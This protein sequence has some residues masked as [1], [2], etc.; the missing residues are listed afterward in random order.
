MS[1][2]LKNNSLLLA[3]LLQ[4]LPLVKTV[5]T[6]PAVASTWAIVFRWAVGSTAA[7]GAFDS[8][9][10]ATSVFTTPS[11]FNGAVGT[12]FSAN[13]TVSIGGGNN[14]ASNDYL[15]VSSGGVNSPL[16]LNNQ[17]TT[18]TMPPGLT[19]TATWVNGATTI[20]GKITGTPTTAG[21]YTT[22][23]TVVSPGNASLSQNITLYIT[24]SSAPTAP[25]FTKQPA[26]TNVIAGRNAVFGVTCSGTT[27]MTYAW[28]KN[29]SPL[30]DGG[31]IS[32]SS[33]TT[34]TV[35]GVS[36]NDAGS[37]TMTASNSVGIATS[38][39]AV[40]TVIEA[41][42]ITAQPQPQNTANGGN[43]TF[44]VTA[45]GTA[46]LAYSWQK[47]GGALANGG[48][49]SGATS[50]AL[51][52]AGIATTDAGNYSVVISNPA[53]SVTSSPAALA[54]VSS[55]TIS[56]PLA[57]K[58]VAV[59]T[60]VAFTITAAG[61]APL[62]YFWQRNGSA[63]ADGGN[64]VGSSTA[65]LNLSSLTTND[66]GN[67]SVI[68]SNALGT[69]TNSATLTVLAPATIVT[70]PVGSTVVAGGSQ[71]FTVIAS[72]SAPLAYQWRKNGTNL[73]GANTATL[74]LVNISANA[75][76][77]YSVTVSNAVGGAVSA[78]A[79]L[80]VLTPP[81]LN[82]QPQN[83]TVKL[84][85]NAT[86]NVN[87]A[88]TAPI[89]FQWS[90]D[91]QPL[92][93]GGSVSGSG[94]NVLTLAGVTTNDAG[95]YSVALANTAG[96]TNS[97]S[98]SLTIIV[99]PSILTAPAPVA[100]TIGNPAGFTVTADGT[101]PLVFQWRKNGVNIPG[102]TSAA[103][104]FAS[105]TATNAG[106]YSVAVSNAGGS[107]TSAVAALTV[108]LP[109]AISAQPTTQAG[110]PGDTVSLTVGVT[111]TAPFNF[112]WFKAGAPLAD[113]GIV[114]GANTATLTL[115]GITTNDLDVYQVTI[116]NAYGSVTSAVAAVSMNVSPAIITQPA[117]QNAALSNAVS[118][119]AGVTG[120]SPLAWQWRN[121]GVN[122]TGATNAV[123]N[124]ASVLTNQNGN[125]SVVVTNRFGR[126]TSAVVTLKVFIPP[127]F[128]RQATNRWAKS[129]TSTIFSA[130][131]SGTAPL[132]FQWF[133]DGVPLADQGT[134]SGAFSNVLTVANLTESDAGA[135]AL[136]AGNFA[137]TVT[138]S[139]GVLTVVVPPLILVQPADAVVVSSNA[140]AF[141]V[142][143]AGTE[144]LF[145][146]WRKA[147]VNIAGATNAVFSIVAVKTNDAARYSVVVTNRA[148]SVVSSNAL[149]TVL[150]PPAFTLQATN[151]WAKLGSN[152]V[153]RAAVSGT[154]PFAFQWFKDGAPL[155]DGG[156]ISGAFSNVLTLAKV[157]TNDTGVYS[158]TATNA[159]GTAVSSNATLTV[160]VPPMIL[161]HPAS[162]AVVLSNTAT[163]SVSVVGTEKL[164]Y[165][166]RKAGVNLAGAT[167]VSFTINS[168][169]TN[170]AAL[171]SVMVTNRAGSVT[172]SNALLTVLLPPMF[173][174]Q[175][176]NRTVTVGTA[177]IFYATVK[178]TAPFT[179]QWLKNGSPLVNGGNIS[180]AQ[181]NVL[182][183]AS[184]STRDAGNYSLAIT[185][186]AGGGVSS[187]ALLI[188]KDTWHGDDEEDRTI[189]SKQVLRATVPP[190]N[191]TPTLNLILV[192]GGI[193]LHC[194]GAPQAVFVLEA[195]TDLE[196]WTDINTNTAD[197]DG[198]AHFTE[199]KAAAIKFY[200]IRTAP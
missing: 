130:A 183:I 187:N 156:T 124:F 152:T 138:S 82:S 74:S 100:V 150:V 158:L 149:L 40:L 98:A 31:N 92:A 161:A 135:Y 194:Q 188:V 16:L 54:V 143:A 137:G 63:I 71:S 192:N 57:S 35:S 119:T 9:S 170:D 118:F 26:A 147:G 144:K 199:P 44:T 27:P 19:F 69:A 127:T 140:A 153:F 21:T 142:T 1:Y 200:R 154:A 36:A 5:C 55:P 59:G 89:S 33:T 189:I 68:V 94:S 65:T 198:A 112:Q 20:G 18:V 2:R 136:T 43:A 8:V 106:N 84:G 80:A 91:S 53:G 116:A 102:A 162:I 123:L 155:A 45:T 28:A 175:A 173:T 185:N 109:P 67:Y 95:N 176:S 195:T 167:N 17:S 191:V 61:S 97:F 104:A 30:A 24:G 70:S 101:A 172:S 105:V 51:T 15:Y 178:G 160:I 107:V 3:A 42:T 49:I 75:A 117:S 12:P 10:G 38:T 110:L 190:A 182:N 50:A 126:A 197:A 145:Y 164:F 48:K 83:A 131:I 113:G 148:G 159:A 169:K 120:S 96:S 79:Y 81:T 86:F 41:P 193:T 13:V 6:H 177:T 32:G 121:N 134:I 58:T 60:T 141:T 103:L 90:K 52:L 111:G 88:G 168:V 62:F 165:Q 180:G 37:Y 14:A 46:P 115:T 186:D 157:T 196:Q 129:G 108:F 181:S 78:D 171:Y 23:V 151:R 56:T 122:L 132:N 77:N 146:Q 184:V 128:N 25:A 163:L 76:G 114:S 166:W 72:G 179:Y 39:N 87:F 64:V 4:L 22:T 29:N 174:L 85:A 7:I 11:T 73:A 125:Y 133:K 47:N 93:D 139:N 66:T 99:P 34:L